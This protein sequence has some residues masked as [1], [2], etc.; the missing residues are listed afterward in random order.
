MRKRAAWSLYLLVVSVASAQG[1]AL[2]STTLYLT[3]TDVRSAVVPAGATSTLL[4]FTVE[5]DTTGGNFFDVATSNPAVM[6]GRR[7]EK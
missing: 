2:P 5:G 4:K 3:A 6:R 7:E 1:V